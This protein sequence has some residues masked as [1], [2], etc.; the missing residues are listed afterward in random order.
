[1]GQIAGA[2]VADGR[3]QRFTL[4]YAQPPVGSLRFANPLNIVSFGTASSVYDA[5]NLPPRC[6]QY[7]E[8]V[9]GGTEPSEDCL[10]SIVYKPTNAKHGDKLPVLV[11]VHGGSGIGGGATNAG[12]D[13]SNLAT[14]RNVI[15][16]VLQYRLGLFGWLQTSALV[17]ESNGGAPNGTKVSG[18]MAFRDVVSALQQL[19]S[20]AR[21]FGGDP[22]LVTLIGQSSGAQL[23]RSL[24]TLPVAAPL[25][26]RAILISDTEDY[27]PATQAQAN[28]LGDYAL[29][30]LGCTDL[31]CARAKDKDDILNVSYDTY[32]TVPLADGSIAGGTP[33]RPTLGKYLP[34]GIEVGKGFP[35]P[36]ILSTVANEAGTVA[37]SLFEPS[38]LNPG[39]NLSAQGSIITL[40]QGN[41]PLPIGQAL[42]L[43]FNQNRGVLATN[44]A[45]YSPGSPSSFR[46]P[47]AGADDAP[48]K[49][50]EEI[51]TDG[52]WRC[53]TQRNARTLASN[54]HGKGIW[55][56]QRNIGARYPSNE[57]VDYCEAAG[58]VCHEDDIYL[59][60]GTTPSP[61]DAQ[62]KASSEIQ[63][64]YSAFA[65]TGNPNVIGKT[66][67]TQV[68]DGN[69]IDLLVYDDQGNSSAQK[70]QRTSACNSNDAWGSR[71]K[72]DWQ[73]YSY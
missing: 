70:G 73:I 51:A 52:L 36:V 4:P 42:N 24:L 11:W 3:A 2:S 26:Q 45:A 47:S 62:Q 35:K 72:F 44:V 65:R 28:T 46:V 21:S 64:R 15:V 29:K 53:A 19:R 27:G 33:W 41:A 39:Q 57:G 34:S 6:Y 30:A 69:D 71:V 14:S 54:S 40:R 50:F 55:L 32:S 5:S 49:L 22:K 17:D 59:I 63:A 10:Y 31:A 13:G 61:T 1:M 56:E 67:W 68:G 8:D 12:L 43:I 66:I 48:R 16:V 38:T 60:F 58:T 20:V 18:N 25:F 9:R 37:G 7:G 23:I